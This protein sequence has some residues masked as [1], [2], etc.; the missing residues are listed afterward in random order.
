MGQSHPLT[1]QQPILLPKAMVR[2]WWKDRT[3]LATV[4]VVL[5]PQPLRWQQKRPNSFAR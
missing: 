4:G 2:F 3:V 1:W 5:R